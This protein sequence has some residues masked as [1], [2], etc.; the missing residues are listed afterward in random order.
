LSTRSISAI[1]KS[2]GRAHEQ[3]RTELLLELADGDA[4]RRLCHVQ[5]RGRATEVE[6]L[7][8]GDEIVQV[9]QLEHRSE[10]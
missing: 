7:R 5:S 2:A 8:D 3:I 4:E 10:H 6:L 9:T 1:V